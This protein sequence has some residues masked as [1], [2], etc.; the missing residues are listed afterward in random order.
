M[1]PLLL[2]LT[3]TLVGCAG[4][5]Q[6]LSRALAQGQSHAEAADDHLDA[7]LEAEAAGQPATPSILLAK[8][9]VAV[10]R[11]QL[12]VAQAQIPHLKN[13]GP[14][15]EDWLRLFQTWG[16]IGLIVAVIGLLAYLGLGPVIRRLLNAAGM[17]IPK[18][19]AADASGDALLLATGEARGLDHARIARWQAL[20]PA[21]RS[22]LAR[23]KKDLQRDAPHSPSA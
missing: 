3:L 20:D 5:T 23:A 13:A 16:Y 22:A 6:T 17:F 19:V 2:L 11:Q 4:G 8:D 15:I 18:P 1:R 12:G 14:S 9:E 21:Y 7:A 10:I